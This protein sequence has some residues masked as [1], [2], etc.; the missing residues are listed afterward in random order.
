MP[1]GPEASTIGGTSLHAWN[2]GLD[3]LITHGPNEFELIENQKGSTWKRE[4]EF[5]L[6]GR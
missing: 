4:K 3:K 6:R 5:L 1:S 2:D